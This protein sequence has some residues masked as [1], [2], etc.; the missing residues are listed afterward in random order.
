MKHLRGACIGIF[1]NHLACEQP[2]DEVGNHQ[3]V[4]GYIEQRRILRSHRIELVERVD[5]HKLHAGLF[6]NIRL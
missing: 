2:I 5:L 6:E 4:F 3:K 1:I